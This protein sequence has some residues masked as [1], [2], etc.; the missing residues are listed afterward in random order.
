MQTI[1]VYGRLKFIIITL[2]TIINFLFVPLVVTLFLYARNFT[3]KSHLG[4]LK[5]S[6]GLVR[7]LNVFSET[8][9]TNWRTQSFQ[10][11]ATS[12][13]LPILGKKFPGIP[14]VLFLWREGFLI[15][16]GNKVYSR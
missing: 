1:L 16:K 6:E 5:G 3:E 10:V 14:T 7:S 13:L 9:V 4:T 12:R 11:N 8:Q 15:L 2:Q